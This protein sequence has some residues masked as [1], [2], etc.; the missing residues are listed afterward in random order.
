VLTSSIPLATFDTKLD[1]L[2]FI[3]KDDL[4]CSE[5]LTAIAIAR[6]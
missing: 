6:R 1:S 5:V 3:A 4:R 2:P